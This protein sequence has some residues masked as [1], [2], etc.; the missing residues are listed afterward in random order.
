MHH[1]GTLPSELQLEQLPNRRCRAVAPLAHDGRWVVY[2]RVS[3][4]DQREDPDGR[5]VGLWNGIEVHDQV[6]VM[7]LRN[8][9]CPAVSL[10]GK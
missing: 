7:P 4:G 6:D 2:A 1:A 9:S 10:H 5:W 3:S 8:C